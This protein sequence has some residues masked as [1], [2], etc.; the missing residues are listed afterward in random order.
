MAINTIWVYDD[1]ALIEQDLDLILSGSG[2]AVECKAKNEISDYLAN[3]TDK[4]VDLII[5]NPSPL[6]D[7]QKP[8]ESICP[9]ILIS[10]HLPQ[11][12]LD[13][14]TTVRGRLLQKP[15]VPFQLKRL[16]N[17]ISVQLQ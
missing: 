6:V 13:T 7:L 1:D 4:T 2:Y 3:A 9:L 11:Y 17:D 5:S 15:F 10:G 14:V 8:P 16:V 12:S